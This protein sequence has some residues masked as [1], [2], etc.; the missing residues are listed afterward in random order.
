MQGDAEAV[1][2][3]DG[4][5]AFCTHVVAM[6]LRHLPFSVFLCSCR[7]PS[8]DRLCRALGS[9]APDTFAYVDRSGAFQ[10]AQAYRRILSR[11][12]GLWGADLAIRGTPDFLV[13]RAYAWVA[14]HRPLMSR[15]VGGAKVSLPAARFIAEGRDD[16]TVAR[17]ADAEAIRVREG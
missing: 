2:L 4:H 8:G 16:S 11:A 14:A 9:A 3:F 1:V 5:C 6:L 7:A 13:R 12:P 15:L 10:G 17:P